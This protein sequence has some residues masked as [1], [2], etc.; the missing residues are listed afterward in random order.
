MNKLQI[1]SGILYFVKWTFVAIVLVASAM[2]IFMNG[3]PMIISSP[4][5]SISDTELQSSLDKILNS[6]N[7]MTL[8]VEGISAQVP[9]SWTLQLLGAF[10]LIIHAVFILWILQI[11]INIVHDVKNKDAF[12]VKNIARLKQVS[13]LL[14][15]LPFFFSATKFIDLLVIGSEYNLPD[16]LTYSWVDNTNFDFLT[17]GFLLYAI[18]IAF[19]EGLKMKQENELTI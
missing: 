5:I 19:G 17:I 12:T 15:L 13:L 1:I 8:T 6:N 18:A 2:L 16:T 9:A 3:E 7:G 11:I 14:I 4:I 10:T